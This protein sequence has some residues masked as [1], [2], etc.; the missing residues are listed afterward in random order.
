MSGRYGRFSTLLMAGAAA[1]LALTPVQA[2]RMQP[3]A[4]HPRAAAEHGG[5][6]EHVVRR[7]DTLSGIAARYLRSARSWPMLLKY[8][9]IANPHLIFPGQRVVVPVADR[10]AAE[11]AIRSAQAARTEHGP[12]A[13]ADDLLNQALAALRDGDFGL[14]FG[15]AERARQQYAGEPE[16]L[17]ERAQVSAPLTVAAVTGEC[18]HQAGSAEPVLLRPGMQI[19][20]GGE[21]LTGPDGQVR[22]AFTDGSALVIEGSS[23]VKLDLARVTMAGEGRYAAELFAGSTVWQLNPAHGRWS[24]TGPGGKAMLLGGAAAVSVRNGRMALSAWQGPI[25]ALTRDGEANVPSGY[26]LIIRP[27]EAPGAPTPLPA[28]PQLVVTADNDIGYRSPAEAVELKLEVARDRDFRTLAVNRMV[29][30]GASFDLRQLAEGDYFIRMSTTAASGLRGLP[31]AA[32][33]WREDR[34][35]PALTVTRPTEAILPA[36]Q[37]EVTGR[38]EPTAKVTVNGVMAQMAADGSFTATVDVTPGVTVVLVEAADPAGNHTILQ[39]A[40][41]VTGDPQTYAARDGRFF[42]RLAQL[43]VT[44]PVAGGRVSAGERSQSATASALQFSLQEGENRLRLQ[45]P[46]SEGL[47]DCQVQVWRD[48]DGPALAGSIKVTTYPPTAEG[49]TAQMKVVI[50]ARD[51]GIGLAN[52]ASADFHS[53]TDRRY[54]LTLPYD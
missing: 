34:T 20:E 27:G 42:T 7:G 50:P 46:T 19:I 14:A 9:R 40:L 10:A 51:G 47:R 49:A 5:F 21:V 23:R 12:N 30:D 37:V 36:G 28:A 45:V 15:L 26:G 29:E 17:A 54:H 25:T 13:A 11:A 31:G 35:A 8:N 3:L 48:Q 38:T 22:L 1:M 24:V 44:M 18:F 41:A 52:Y 16:P 39:R 32:L 6:T 53:A 43:P 33:A 2:A 4:A